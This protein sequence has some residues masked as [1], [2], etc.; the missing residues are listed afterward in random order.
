MRFYDCELFLYSLHPH[1]MSRL[2]HERH[3]A[4]GTMAHDSP[5]YRGTHLHRSGL[6]SLSKRAQP[7]ARQPGR[8][9]LHKLSEVQRLR[10]VRTH[11][12]IHMCW[13]ILYE[14]VNRQVSQNHGMS[15]RV[16]SRRPAC[17]QRFHTKRH[18]ERETR[19]SFSAQMLTNL[20]LQGQ[21]HR[22][23]QLHGPA[24]YQSQQQVLVSCKQQ[25][26]QQQQQHLCLFNRD[27]DKS[28]SRK[29]KPYTRTKLSR[30]GLCRSHASRDLLKS[31]KHRSSVSG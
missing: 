22:L 19:S 13:P 25:Q 6:E 28:L 24:L 21:R 15:F 12:C 4:L 20:V 8:C 31:D 23:G 1:T 3:Q 18:F 7:W 17:A 5:E 30:A 16:C 2:K 10:A 29:H 11:M 27:P 26:Q 9:E 14:C